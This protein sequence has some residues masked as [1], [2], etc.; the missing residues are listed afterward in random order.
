MMSE[1]P[2]KIEA[3]DEA[4]SIG[5]V[6]PEEE[7]FKRIGDSV[8]MTMKQFEENIS[9]ARKESNQFF[10]L[11]LICVAAGFIVLLVSITFLFFEKVAIGV[12]SA[13]SSIIPEVTAALFFGKD[14]ELRK[15][16]ER[17][18]QHV[19]NSQNLLT[20]IDVAETVQN[21]KERDLIKQEIIHK[22]LAIDK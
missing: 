9:Q 8:R 22:V 19:F 4:Q 18:D 20:M 1:P 15:A 12:V 10:R 13:A 5:S 21:P 7:A 11:T 2:D 6:F 16:I 14:K 3:D 17:H